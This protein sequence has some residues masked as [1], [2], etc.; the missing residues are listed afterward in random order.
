VPGG[1]QQDYRLAAVVVSLSA[2]WFLH[3]LSRHEERLLLDR[4]G[5]DYRAYIR[6]V[7]MWIPRLRKNKS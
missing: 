5:D 4:F 7:G 1:V 3:Y 6:E 2:A